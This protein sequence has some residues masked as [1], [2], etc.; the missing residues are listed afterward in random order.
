MVTTLIEPTD[1]IAECRSQIFRTKDDLTLL[2][3]KIANCAGAID[4]C[5]KQSK[6]SEVLKKIIQLDN[7]LGDF[8]DQLY[9]LQIKIRRIEE[10]SITL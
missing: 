1:T 4:N 9:E 8:D 5:L 6:H 2:I 10:M 3:R 7:V